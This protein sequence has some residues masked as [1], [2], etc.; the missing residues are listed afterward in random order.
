MQVIPASARALIESAPLAHFVTINPDGSPH[1][2][3]VW[4]GMDGDHVY[5]ATMV[6]HQ[7]I[8][9]IRRDPRVVISIESPEDIAPGI[10]QYLVLSG[11]AEVVEGGGAEALQRLAHA[12][13]GPDTVFPDMADPPPG[14]VVKVKVER[15]RGVGPWMEGN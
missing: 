7:K 6:E 9:N 8:R 4:V 10:Q 1:V 3:C 15:I 11:H 2:T 5:F 12:Y 14:F 13:M